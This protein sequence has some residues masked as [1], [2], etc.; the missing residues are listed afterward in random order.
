MI[1]VGIVGATGYTGYEL[2]KI[3]LNHP[4]VNIE[5]ITSRSYSGKKIAEVFPNL[6]SV[7]DLVCQELN[8]EKLAN[9]CDVV[10]IALPHG[11]A[12]QVASAV[13]A[14][15]K[16]VIDLG[17]D[18]RLTDPTV[19]SEWYQTKPVPNHLL[20]QA[21]YGLPELQR[22]Q[23]RSARIIA[24]SG[25]Y[26]TS[27]ILAL[28]P[29]IKKGLIDL[30]SIIVD[31]K[32]GVSGAGRS[33]NIGSHYAEGNE[34]FKAY[35]I[36][37]H[38]HTPEIEQ[39][40]GKLAD[41]DLKISFTPHLVPMTRGILATVY[42]HIHD[43]ITEKQVEKIYEH[44]YQGENFVHVLT[45][46]LPETKWVAGTNNCLLAVKVDERTRRLV[47]VSAIDNLVKG[48]AGQAVQNMNLMCAIDEKTGLQ[49]I[50]RYL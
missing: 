34:N 9:C 20:Q 48:A 11:H 1:K 29:A 35:K 40:L 33:L 25:C 45:D 8:V 14:K 26:P 30:S 3:L 32:S 19:Y 46:N 42:A 50:G 4:A 13:V 12:E 47:V 23:V 5:I 38:R 17:A 36:A 24:N 21:V 7:T 6:S 10:F 2:V 44:F 39:E 28:A 15:G 27:A 37:S 18:F 41:Q 43:K 16:K 31:A 22:E 49:Y